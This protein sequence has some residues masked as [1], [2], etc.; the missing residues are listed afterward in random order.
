MRTQSKWW[1]SP[2]RGT[3]DDPAVI[4]LFDA[5]IHQSTYWCIVMTMSKPQESLRVVGYIRV[6]TEE[7][8]TSGAGLDAQRAAIVAEVELRGWQLAGVLEDAGI[9]GKSMTG[10]PGLAAAIGTVERGDAQ[11]IVVAKLDRLSRSLLDFAGLMDRARRKGWSLVALDLQLDMTTPAGEM[12]AAVM[13]TFAQFERRLIGQRTRDAL[14]QKRLDGVVLGRPRTM[15][16]EVRER[17]RH[18]RAAGRSY[19]AIA[20]AL[21]A[22]GVP[23]A[24]GGRRWHA[25]TVR[26]AV[27][28]PGQ[29]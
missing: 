22:E 4:D 24:Q 27:L 2:A 6:S 5:T 21:T 13:A 18:D 28:G 15:D 14:A 9:S 3:P 1:T 7:Q 19:A 29:L 8:A 16:A 11:A 25:S 12:M 10:R 20:D 26:K 23:T 17:I